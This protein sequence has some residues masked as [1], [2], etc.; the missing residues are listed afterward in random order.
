MNAFYEQRPEKLFIGE[1]THYPVAP[2][3]IPWRSW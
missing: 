1:M 3:C 2:T